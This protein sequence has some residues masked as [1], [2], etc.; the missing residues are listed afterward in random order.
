MLTG[1]VPLVIYFVSAGGSC[2]ASPRA[3]EGL[4][5]VPM[6]TGSGERLIPC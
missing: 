2:A 4:T 1:L 6:T 5:A 3:P